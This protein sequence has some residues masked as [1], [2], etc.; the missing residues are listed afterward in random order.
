MEWIPLR[1]TTRAPVLLINIAWRC[2]HIKQ[3][4][5]QT[6]SFKGSFRTE[7]LLPLEWH[8]SNI[9]KYPKILL[10]NDWM[11]WILNRMWKD[12]P[13]VT[14]VNRDDN[15]NEAHKI[16]LSLMKLKKVKVT[17]DITE[18]R[19]QRS[20]IIVL[21]K[22]VLFK[23]EFCFSGVCLWPSVATATSWSSTPH[24]WWEGQPS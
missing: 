19:S 5:L 6:H 2:A 22:Y 4:L 14:S 13:D 1:L 18:S 3:V 24:L 20:T 10:R 23:Y 17:Y 11:V 16:I 8:Q 7:F 9:L 21:F 15:Q 12:F